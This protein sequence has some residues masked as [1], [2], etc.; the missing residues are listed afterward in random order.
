MRSY[1]GGA[2]R[3]AAKRSRDRLGWV[4]VLGILLVLATGCGVRDPRLGRGSEFAGSFRWVAGDTS[5][6]LRNAHYFKLMGQPAVALKQLE[7][8]HRLYPDNL[9]VA[10]ALAQSYDGSGLHE[11][12]QQIYQAALALDPDNPVLLNNLAFSYYLAGKGRQAE[13]C[14]RKA[15]A[16]HPDN[17]A[18]RNNLGL[19]LCRQGRRQEARRLW[20]ESGG[21]A[22]AAHQLAQALAALGRTGTPRYGQPTR[23]NP[24][25]PIHRRY[26]PPDTRLAAQPRSATAKP[27]HSPAPS[28][29]VNKKSD[30]KTRLAAPPPG[31][32]ALK[33]AAT[34]PP[35]Q[36]ASDASSRAV[37][38]PKPLEGQVTARPPLPP[39]T[40]I[41]PMVRH[42]PARPVLPRSEPAAGP[43]PAST[44]PP[45]GTPARP[46]KA[47]PP[48]VRASQPDPKGTAGATSPDKARAP[49]PKYL[50]ARDLMETGIAILNGNGIPHL[51]HDT[52]SSLSLE[53]FNVVAIA[54]YRDFGVDRTVIYYRP[55]S[56]HVATYLNKKFFPRAAV[57]PA[58]Q[59]ADS[60]DVKVILGHDLFPQRCA[61]AS[62]PH[63]NKSL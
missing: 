44:P 12:A 22:A 23:P 17:L 39:M 11:E 26:A 21:E 29:A 53:G 49:R 47:A 51:A 4:L 2:S 31:V 18:L 20:Q 61:G 30:P 45:T 50:T 5:R 32:P 24:D 9:I 1:P 41:G 16:R 54:N 10:D 6:L 36:K 42:R 48:P 8:A 33:L 3:T 59:L 37:P 35:K 58:P 46:K 28:P 25:V 55:E 27:Q 56:E 15:L 52:R 7:E 19:L 13:T 60:I 40:A 57:E 14:F 38:A 62:Q 63:G 34:R 43:P